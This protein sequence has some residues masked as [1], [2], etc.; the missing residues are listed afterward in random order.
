MT[1]PK[2]AVQQQSGTGKKHE[3]HGN[4]TNDEDR[5]SP[6]AG[7]VASAAALFHR[8][9]RV[10]PRGVK[11]GYDAEDGAGDE[12][13]QEG[14]RGD[15]RVDA[16]LRRPRNALRHHAHDQADKPGPEQQTG[17]APEYAEHQ[18]LGEQ[19]SHESLT[20]GPERRANRQL[21]ATS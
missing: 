2:E 6:S 7:R 18:A 5:A 12:R 21:A 10:G 13:H 8:C 20:P 11:R 4:L 9:C 17:H 14:G 15:E 1:Q 3:G 16:D 19:Q